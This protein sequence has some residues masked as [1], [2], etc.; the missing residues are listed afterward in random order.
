MPD[1]KI[2]KDGTDYP[3]QTMPLHYPADRVYLNGDTT[4]TVQDALDKT[5]YSH[6]HCQ[7]Y[8]CNGFILIIFND[9]RDTDSC[10]FRVSRTTYGIG[11]IY[12][13]LSS[14]NVHINLYTNGNIDVNS[15]ANQTLTTYRLYGTVWMLGSIHE[16]S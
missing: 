1:V 16:I 15:S 13:L 6:G 10:P 7:V 4:K 2:K 8:E 5:S 12:D 3:L 9:F 11:G 14:D